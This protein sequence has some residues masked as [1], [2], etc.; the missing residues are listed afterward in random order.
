ME[1]RDTR[2]KREIKGALLMKMENESVLVQ[3]RGVTAR[4]PSYPIGSWKCDE[5]WTFD[6]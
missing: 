2:V 1:G 6:V 4:N 3:K 5:F